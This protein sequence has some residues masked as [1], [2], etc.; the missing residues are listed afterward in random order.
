MIA[1]TLTE[2]ER[3][4]I[5]E[6]RNART[7]ADRHGRPVTLVIMVDAKTTTAGTVSP[8]GRYEHVAP[9]AELKLNKKM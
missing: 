7:L 6:L 8:L 1:M 5:L 9:E 3:R 2:D 4:L